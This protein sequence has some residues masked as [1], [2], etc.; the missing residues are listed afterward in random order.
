M[1]QKAILWVVGA[2]GIAVLTILWV[3]RPREEDITF[4]VV[5]AETGK[6]LKEFNIQVV[7]RWARLPLDEIGISPWRYINFEASNGARTVRVRLDRTVNV[8]FEATDHQD[9]HICV[10][11]GQPG[12]MK[13]NGDTGWVGETNL[14]VIPLPRK[15]RVD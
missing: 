13:F 5:D 6:D 2:F 15:R 8:N 7:E 11:Q 10:L 3:K 9:R 1:R 14:I 4:R 12:E